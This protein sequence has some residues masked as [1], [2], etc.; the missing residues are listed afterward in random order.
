VTPPVSS[1]GTGGAGGEQAQEEE[2]VPERDS[3]SIAD[4][5]KTAFP[6]VALPDVVVQKFS[7]VD[8]DTFSKMYHHAELRARLS[9]HIVIGRCLLCVCP[10]RVCVCVCVRLL[11]DRVWP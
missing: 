6:L 11:V 1:E 10:V 9:A 2:P 3:V 5:I 8:V 7:R 4:A